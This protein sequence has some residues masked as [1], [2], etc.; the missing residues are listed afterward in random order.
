MKTATVLGETWYLIETEAQ[1]RA[2]GSESYPLSAKYM[3]YADITLTK[4]EDWKPLGTFDVPFT[5][6]FIGNGFEIIDLTITDPNVKVIGMFA[7]VQNANIGNI[8]LR[9]PDI[10][11]AFRAGSSIAPIVVFGLG[12]NKIYDNQIIN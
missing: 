10:E 5:G 1:L 3:L 2:I 8:T 7:Y 6:A 4:T 11:S 12:N 9:N